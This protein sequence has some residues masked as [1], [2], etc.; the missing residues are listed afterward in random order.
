MTTVKVTVRAVAMGSLAMAARAH[1]AA[2]RTTRSPAV[3]DLLN[4][5]MSSS[6]TAISTVMVG[7]EAERDAVRNDGGWPLYLQRFGDLLKAE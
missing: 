5:P 2:G 3:V 4:G 6:S 1:L 7:G